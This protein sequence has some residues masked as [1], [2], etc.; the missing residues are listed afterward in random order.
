MYLYSLGISLSP[1]DT[2]KINWQFHFLA[3]R[4]VTE[5]VVLDAMPLMNIKHNNEKSLDI[6]NK[7]KNHDDLSIFFSR[8]TLVGV[9]QT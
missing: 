8:D 6:Y 5:N 9:A 7:K 1:C 4:P 2:Q 3:D